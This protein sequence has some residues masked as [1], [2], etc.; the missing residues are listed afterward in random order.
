[1]QVAWPRIHVAEILNVLKN[2]FWQFFSQN[3]C[4][5]FAGVSNPSWNLLNLVREMWDNF[6]RGWWPIKQFSFIRHQPK[7]KFVHELFHSNAPYYLCEVLWSVVNENVCYD[8]R[9][10]DNVRQFNTRTE[11]FRSIF[12][13]CQKVE[14]VTW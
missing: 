1:M 5:V 2:F 4:K 13:D 8:L 14:W 10:K 6:V 9:N 3:S 7:F 11:M 12:P